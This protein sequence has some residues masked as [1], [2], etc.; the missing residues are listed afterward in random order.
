MLRDGEVLH[1]S[2]FD[3]VQR[4]VRERYGALTFDDID[5]GA[6]RFHD[7][8]GNPAGHRP[9]YVVDATRRDDEAR[10]AREEAQQQYRDE[11]ENAWRTPPTGA[12][13][14]G[15]I[16]QRPISSAHDNDSVM[17]DRETAHVEYRHRIEN[18]WRNP[19]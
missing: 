14:R 1:V 19:T 7:G 8:R 3:S 18:A 9:G 13:E 15:Q 10:V 6:P 4:E 16:G 11:L 12:N 5:R 17:T 2:L